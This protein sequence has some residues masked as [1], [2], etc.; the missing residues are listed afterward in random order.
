MDVSIR[1]VA[2]LVGTTSRTL[3][4]YEAVGLVRPS[5][6]APGGMRY[7]DR[8]ALVRLQRVLLLRQ[9]GMGLAAIAEA[10]DGGTSDV[11]ALRAHVGRLR[12][13]RARIE[14]QIRAV[15]RT[16]AASEEGATQM[17]EEMFEGFDGSQYRE[18]VE[19]RWGRHAYAR[20]QEWWKGLGDDG[21]RDF[22]AEQAAI[23]DAWQHAAALG[24][25]TDDERVRALAERH[26]AWMAQAWGGVR[27]TRD[28]VVGLAE[29]YVADER[30]AANYGGPRGARYV[31]DV[32]L[33]HAG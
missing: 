31:R 14:R 27:P 5:R 30:F 25:A 13:Q 12:Q 4:H 15:E 29:M 1:Q 28:Q 18:E 7:Y 19:Q 24:L 32:L 16:I 9:S 2:S 33:A 6:V 20:S 23:A 21:R 3:R 10:I 11:D 22:T 8:E 17:A 26:V